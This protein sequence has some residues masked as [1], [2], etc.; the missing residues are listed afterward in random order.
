VTLLVRREVQ[1]HLLS[2]ERPVQFQHT[3]IGSSVNRTTGYH[4]IILFLYSHI[5]FNPF[6]PPI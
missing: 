6:S 2:T 4:L 3:I 5:Y 1:F